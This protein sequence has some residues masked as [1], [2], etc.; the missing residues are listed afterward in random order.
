MKIATIASTFLYVI[1]LGIDYIYIIFIEL[2]ICSLFISITLLLMLYK[3]RYLETM[4]LMKKALHL[5]IK[6]SVS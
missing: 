4:R 6:A 3:Y 1:C 2:Y 5:K